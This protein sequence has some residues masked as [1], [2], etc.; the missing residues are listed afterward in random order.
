M[1]AKETIATLKAVKDAIREPWAWPGGYP[2]Y[3]VMED[4]EALSV[5]AAK[6]EF[7]TIVWAMFHG[8]GGW[9]IAGVE[10]NYEDPDL[11][12]AHTHDR[13]ESAYAEDQAS[14]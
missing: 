10:V 13:I 2:K 7:R 11:Y 14:G 1:I 8:D 9:S 6:A 4:G 3:L 5:G 12:C